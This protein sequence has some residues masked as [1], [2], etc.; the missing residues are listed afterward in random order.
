M[1]VTHLWCFQETGYKSIV[2]GTGEIFLP[3]IQGRG[4]QTQATNQ[5]TNSLSGNFRIQD[6]CFY[7]LHVICDLAWRVLLEWNSFTF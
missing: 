1:H 2:R 3:H 6:M 4:Y 5:H 7:D